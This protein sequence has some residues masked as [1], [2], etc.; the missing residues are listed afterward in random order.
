MSYQPKVYREQGGSELTVAVG[1]YI[2][3]SFAAVTAAGNAQANATALVAEINVVAGADDAKGVILPAA[4]A[5]R[6]IHVKTT[7]AAKTLKVYPP[8]GGKINGGTADAAVTMAAVTA[9]L[10]VSDGTD[11]WTFGGTIS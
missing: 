5:G 11:W 4:K 9:T 6:P 3:H 2:N 10:F 8:T 1:G 7:V